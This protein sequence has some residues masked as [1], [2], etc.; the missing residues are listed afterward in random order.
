MDRVDRSVRHLGHDAAAHSVNNEVG[1][2]VLKQPG[3]ERIV[4]PL[5]NSDY[6]RHAGKHVVE[7]VLETRLQSI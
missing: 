2:D 3:K 6:F 5:M 4:L 1:L 7:D